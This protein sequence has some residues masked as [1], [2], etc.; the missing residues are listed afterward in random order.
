M[1][2]GHRV[3]GKSLAPRRAAA[4]IPSWPGPTSTIRPTAAC[5]W[6]RRGAWSGTC[7]GPAGAWAARLAAEG[8]SVQEATQ[9]LSRCRHV[10]ARQP[11][12]GGRGGAAPAVA[13]A[14]GRGGGQ[15]RGDRRQ[16][17]YP[18]PIG[19]YRGLIGHVRPRADLV[20]RRI[21]KGG[22]IP[23][24]GK[25][26]P[27][28]GP[29]TRWISKG[30]AGVP[31]EPGVPVRVLEDRHGFLPHR[32]VM[33]EG[34][35]VDVAVHMSGEAR[36]RFP[37]LSVVSFDRGPHSPP[38]TGWSLPG[39]RSRRDAPQGQAVEGGPRPGKRGGVPRGAARPR[40]G[41][42]GHQQPGAPR[43]GPRRRPRKGG[44]AGA[45][46]LEVLAADVHRPGLMLRERERPVLPAAAGPGPACPRAG[47]GP[48]V[49][50]MFPPPAV[51]SKPQA[52]LRRARLGSREA[53]IR[54]IR[55]CHRKTRGFLAD[56]IIAT[57]E[58]ISAITAMAAYSGENA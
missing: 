4:V 43:P 24:R 29:H 54:W 44:F 5:R 31:V 23:H 56:T 40:R 32:S 45:V 50:H 38:R 28:S 26:H 21:L 11:A 37:D 22:T 6:T 55:P 10:T 8:T 19:Q 53:G 58:R 41:R 57:A 39:C 33:W 47:G 42:V 15:P 7:P 17:G 51:P 35:D 25:V 2:R 49:H 1:E 36:A 9:A 20:G 14:G 46:A 13:E 34:S 48:D 30:K 18:G 16:F 3:A 52:A 12:P 27:I